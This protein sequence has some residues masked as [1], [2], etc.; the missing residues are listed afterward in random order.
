VKANASIAGSIVG[1]P[2][3]R[4]SRPIVVLRKEMRQK[5]NSHAQTIRDAILRKITVHKDCGAPNK[6][7]PGHCLSLQSVTRI[8]LWRSVCSE[9]APEGCTT[10]RIKLAH[11]G[12]HQIISQ[13]ADIWSVVRRQR[14]LQ[15]MQIGKFDKAPDCPVFTTLPELP[16]IDREVIRPLGSLMPLP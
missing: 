14:T 13:R 10:C 8:Q 6:R 11:N 5:F 3:A 4:T 16:E 7:R 1:E 2:A 9:V 15:L 12:I